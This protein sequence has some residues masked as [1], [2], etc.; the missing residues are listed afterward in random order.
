M[1]KGTSFQTND[2]PF[3]FGSGV[4]AIT[5]NHMLGIIIIGE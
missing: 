5:P 1:L 3:S 2:V 4:V